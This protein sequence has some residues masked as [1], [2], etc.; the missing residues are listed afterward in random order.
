MGILDMSKMS[1]ILAQVVVSWAALGK[2][3]ASA[4]GGVVSL[5][6]LAEGTH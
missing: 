6:T 3:E 1:W 2:Q 5:T 4:P